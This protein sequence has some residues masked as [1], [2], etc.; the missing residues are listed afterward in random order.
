MHTEYSWSWATAIFL[1]LTGVLFFALRSRLQSKHPEVFRGLGLTNKWW[2][3]S[4]NFKYTKWLFTFRYL[5]LGDRSLSVIC[6]ST[7]LV[8]LITIYLLFAQ[9][10]YFESTS[11]P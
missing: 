2:E 11:T 3:S 9:P 6:L 8:W 1:V 4:S 5:T 10:I 7:K